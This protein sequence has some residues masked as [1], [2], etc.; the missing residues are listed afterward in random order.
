MKGRVQVIHKDQDR[1]QENK[2]QRRT[3]TVSKKGNTQGYMEME[4]K[5]RVR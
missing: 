4:D 3:N 2:N 1:D 5:M